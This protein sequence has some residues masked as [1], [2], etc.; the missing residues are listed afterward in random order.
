M[1]AQIEHQETDLSPVFGFLLCELLSQF[2]DGFVTH[3]ITAARTNNLCTRVPT[4][5]GWITRGWRRTSW[6]CRT[7]VALTA[8][9]TDPVR[10]F[11]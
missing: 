6:R 11:T 1:S 3:V 4:E 8:V 10:S 5:T 2:R 7:S 9:T